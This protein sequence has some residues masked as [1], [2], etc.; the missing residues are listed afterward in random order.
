L[1][2]G[3]STILF[4]P[5]TDAVTDDA[6]PIGASYSEHLGQFCIMLGGRVMLLDGVTGAG[7][8][9]SSQLQ[10]TGEPTAMCIDASHKKLAIGTQNGEALLYNGQSLMKEELAKAE[11]HEYGI[12]SL[13]SCN[14]G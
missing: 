3:G 9:W 8:H 2:V 13:L 7:V 14:D 10:T 4:Y 12:C 1:L 6:A 5:V 11:S